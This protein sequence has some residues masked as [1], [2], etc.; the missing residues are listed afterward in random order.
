[1]LKEKYCAFSII[2]LILVDDGAAVRAG[3]SHYMDFYLLFHSDCPAWQSSSDCLRCKL[4][5]LCKLCLFCVSRELCDIGDIGKLTREQFALALH[6]IN[7]R[8]TKGLEPPQSLL[9][10][11]I[12]P[13]DRQSIKQ[14]S[15]SERLGL[16]KN[17]NN[18]E[19]WGHLFYFHTLVLNQNLIQN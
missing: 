11:M 13:S 5:L 9:P 17:N 3:L 18:Q 6:L 14:V 8:L 19:C 4:L 1:M 2:H 10:E 15:R 12:P 16:W 7:Q